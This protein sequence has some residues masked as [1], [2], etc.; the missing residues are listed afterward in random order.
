LLLK[1]RT[2]PIQQ[3]IGERLAFC[4]GNVEQRKSVIQNVKKVYDIRSSFVHHGENLENQKTLIEFLLNVRIFF[5]QLLKIHDKF[6][7]K[8]EFIGKIKEMKLS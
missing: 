8:S 6:T 1:N 5:L 4:I 3:N 7:Q 2:E